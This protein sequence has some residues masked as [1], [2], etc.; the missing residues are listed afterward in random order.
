MSIPIDNTLKSLKD[1]QSIALVA[2]DMM[3]HPKTGIELTSQILSLVSS[4]GAVVQ[5]LIAA[6]PEFRNLDKDEA[7]Q[8]GG[9]TF[10]LIKAIVD[11]LK[12]HPVPMHAL[13]HAAPV[14]GHPA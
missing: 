4:S 9:A 14:P 10:E 7:A 12:G 6:W 8:L 2:I 11:K 1:I 13:P 5:N 3:Q